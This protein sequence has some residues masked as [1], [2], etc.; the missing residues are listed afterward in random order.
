[1]SDLG[2]DIQLATSITSSL[3]N[4]PLVE[5]TPVIGRGRVNKVFIVE[6]GS[7]R[8][9]IRMSDR[10]DALDEYTKEAWCIEHAAARGV[11][12]PS[13]IGVGRCA[14]DAYIIQ[15]FITGDDGIDS[16]VSKLCIWRELGKHARLIH[17]IGVQ[18]FGPTLSE[19]TQGD[20]R[21]SWLQQLESNIEN[22]TENDPLIKLKVLTQPQLKLIRNVFTDLRGRDFTFGLI[23]GDISLTNTIVDNRGTVY[24]LDWGSAEAGIV[25]HH[26]LIELLMKNM[27][28]GNPDDAQ[29]RAF[30][31]GYGISATEFKQMTPELESLLVLRAFAHLRSAIARNV[32]KLDTLVFHAR[33]CVSYLLRGKSV[34]RSF[35][36]FRSCVS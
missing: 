11:P 28:E 36:Q 26:D 6:T 3:L 21:N 2:T 16:P 34:D 29:T 22:L 8:V 35:G 1:M 5:V 17:S 30:L 15:P 31:D 12:V 18:G 32:E 14:R 19:I 25:P 7:H 4:E 13:V 23:H 20:A 9:V 24:L 10:D 27:L 33:L